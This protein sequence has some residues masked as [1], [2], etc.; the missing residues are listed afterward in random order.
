LLLNLIIQ[1]TIYY[2][3]TIIVAIGFLV[4]VDV[5]YLLTKHTLALGKN[6]N[7]KGS[8][9]AHIRTLI[10]LVEFLVFLIWVQA[11]RFYILRNA[12]TMIDIAQKYVMCL[13]GPGG[14]SELCQFS[15]S[16]IFVSSNCSK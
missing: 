2:P 6:T 9:N 7:G 15:I 10:F 11:N 5:L 8:W 13:M 1:T 14:S 12:D 16:A 4:I 3:V